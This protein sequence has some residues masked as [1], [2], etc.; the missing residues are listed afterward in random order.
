MRVWHQE[1]DVRFSPSTTKVT[2]HQI[3]RLIKLK[4][5]RDTKFCTNRRSRSRTQRNRETRP[6]GAERFIAVAV[7]RQRRDHIF[8]R[9]R[10]VGRRSNHTRNGATPHLSGRLANAF[11]RKKNTQTDSS[12]PRASARPNAMGVVSAVLRRV[13]P[14][15]CH[16]GAAVLQ[17]WCCGF[18]FVCLRSAKR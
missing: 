6:P 11:R 13:P 16:S 5:F 10:P 8:S 14:V 7:H 4:M 1:A 18:V 3:P 12:R 17:H 2:I 9:P 15:R